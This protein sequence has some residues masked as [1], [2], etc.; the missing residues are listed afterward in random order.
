M[1]LWNFVTDSPAVWGDFVLIQT[2]RSDVSLW[3][4]ITPQHF[5]V[6]SCSPN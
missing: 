5:I 2:Y 6:G 1:A 4:Y 3:Q